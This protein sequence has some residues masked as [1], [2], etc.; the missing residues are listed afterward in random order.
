MSPLFTTALA[1]ILDS[2]PWIPDCRYWIPVM[3][4][5]TWILDSNP[6]FLDLYSRFHKQKFPGF[7]NLHSLIWGEWIWIANNTA[8][9]LSFDCGFPAAGTES[10]LL[11]AEVW[12]VREELHLKVVV[13][14]FRLTVEPVA[15]LLAVFWMSRNALRDIQKNVQKTAAR[16]TIE[17]AA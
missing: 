11:L 16:E 9:Q 4:S 6:G 7:Q 17:S 12:E 14:K 2:T 15:S 13:L 3:V 5:G 10:L 8:C 1:W